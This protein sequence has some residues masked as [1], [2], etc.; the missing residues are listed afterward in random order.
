M[1]LP[2]EYFDAVYAASADPWHFESSPY[3][4]EK[5]TTTIAA[6][7][8]DRYACGLEIGCSIG[9]L[10]ERLAPHC[11]HLL[12]IDVNDSA[13]ARARERC[14]ALPQVEFEVMQVPRSFPP[15]Q[16]D[17][18]VVSEVGYYWSKADLALAARKMLGAL[19]DDGSLLLVHWTEPVADYPL[20]GDQ[21]HE[22]FM[23]LVGEGRLGHV[24]G[25]RR[26]HYRLD[27]FACM[28]R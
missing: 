3:E 18:I 10:T 19:R 17:L 7:P 2:P 20:T 12:A 23:Q 16:F 26:P 27:L 21:V 13:L 24:R 5:Y 6:L 11:A 14:A 28:P 4:N 25:E 9:V 1:S 15:G 8:R 22:H